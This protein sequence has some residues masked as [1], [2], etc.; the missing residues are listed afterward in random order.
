MT[1]TMMIPALTESLG[2]PEYSAPGAATWRQG[3]RYARVEASPI[4]HA[5]I[6]ERWTAGQGAVRAT[7]ASTAAD[8]LALILVHFSGADAPK[9]WFLHGLEKLQEAA[10]GRT[11]RRDRDRQG[12]GPDAITQTENPRVTR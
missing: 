3:N 12:R 11:P 2:T 4:D 8:A 5:L 7:V 9:G 10:T 1:M 6:L